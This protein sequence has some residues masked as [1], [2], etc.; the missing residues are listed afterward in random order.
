[1]LTDCLNEISRALMSADVQFKMIG[2]MQANI[3][4]T[5]SLDD[6]AAGHNKRKIIQQVRFRILCWLLTQL[7]DGGLMQLFHLCDEP[8]FLL[9]G[10]RIENLQAVFNELC[11]MLDPGKP[12]FV[13]KKGKPNVIMFVGLQGEWRAPKPL[14]GF[15]SFACVDVEAWWSVLWWTS[16]G[17]DVDG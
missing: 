17:L 12:A 13:P 4:K 5:V 6:R 2:T 9:N 7:L 10:D 8:W 3:K 1:V 16:F 11:N 14:S 15:R